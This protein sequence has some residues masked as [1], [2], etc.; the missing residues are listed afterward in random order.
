[1]GKISYRRCIGCKK[2][3]AKS[4]LLRVVVA[5]GTL[6]LDNHHREQSRGAYLHRSMRCWQSA[7]GRWAR[8]FVTPSMRGRP[9]MVIDRDAE[10]SLAEQIAQVNGFGIR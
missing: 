2:S 8:A 1:M 9:P 5:F 4:E 3:E 7:S 6:K 10:A